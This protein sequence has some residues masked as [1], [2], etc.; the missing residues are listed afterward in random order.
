[1]RSL[2]RDVDLADLLDALAAHWN[3]TFGSLD[4]FPQGGGAY[5]WLGVTGDRRWIVTVD[6]LETKP[7][8]GPDSDSVLPGLLA[9]YQ[10]AL[11]LRRTAGL[12]FV[13]APEPGVSGACAI[14]LSARYSVAVFPFVDGEAGQWNQAVD[15]AERT[16]VVHLL[17]RLHQASPASPAARR[18]A[19]HVP[20][21]ERFEVALADLD[22]SWNAGP[23]A[24]PVRRLLAG[25][26]DVIAGWFHRFDD[27]AEAVRRS[28][29]GAVVTHGEPHP[30][31]LIRTRDGYAL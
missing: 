9:A 7:W 22:R 20:G 8:L 15:A 19:P 4:Y 17:A 2:P 14:R 6:D 24:E 18:H 27:L 10:T 5:H 31:N 3:L 16:R 26:L 23:F 13:V 29:A 12:S 11:E 21:R 30:G 1:M 28:G 25:H